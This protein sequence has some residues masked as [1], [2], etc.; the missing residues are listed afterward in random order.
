MSRQQAHTLL[1]L[2]VVAGLLSAVRASAD[3]DQEV[4]VLLPCST[5]AGPDTTV[6]Q[7]VRWPVGRH[8]LLVDLPASFHLN[9]NTRFVHGG[10]S[11]TDGSRVVSMVGGSQY[12]C[13]PGSKDYP[14][15]HE[16]EQI[17]GEV[18]L[19]LVSTYEQQSGEYVAAAV[20]D[21]DPSASVRLDGDGEA[22]IARS[23]RPEDQVL[24]LRVLG[25]IRSD[26]RVAR[27]GL[28][29]LGGNRLDPPYVFTYVDGRLAV[30]GRALPDILPPLVPAADGELETRESVEAHLVALRDS[31]LAAGTG[32]ARAQQFLTSR[33]RAMPFVDTVAV[34]GRA[35]QPNSKAD[36]LRVYVRWKWGFRNLYIH[37][38]TAYSMGSGSRNGADAWR[39]TDELFF[40]R[41]GRIR[42]RLEAGD[43]IFLMGGGSEV[44]V[45]GSNRGKVLEDIEQLKVDGSHLPSWMP[46]ALRAQLLRPLV[47]RKM[48]PQDL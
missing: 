21:V 48:A 34:A 10:R 33:A 1:F 30:N 42:D 8:R 26:S 24:F 19:R 11:W 43:V 3:G 4:R 46:S 16:C 12:T 38:T 6:W 2:F 36:P 14:G 7:T 39:Q 35:P 31:L 29:F 22:L 37:E 40:R 18:K 9:R 5:P 32:W 45:S 28:L 44:I 27:R 25:S 20:L 15:C 17:L 47:L 13:V 41:A 23:S